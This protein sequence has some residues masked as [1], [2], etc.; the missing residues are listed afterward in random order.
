MPVNKTHLITFKKIIQIVLTALFLTALWNI[1]YNEIRTERIRSFG[2]KKAI[3]M[4]TAREVTGKKHINYWLT[5]S[6]VDPLGICRKRSV[7][8]SKKCWEKHL[9]GD[10]IKVIYP[11]A[12]PGLSRIKGEIESPFVIFMAEFSR[13]TQ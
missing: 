2:E 12:Q 9:G 8:V 13:K 5:Y 3:G 10:S 6:F 11:V 7:A 1:P 4:I